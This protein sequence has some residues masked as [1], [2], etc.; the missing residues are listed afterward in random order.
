MQFLCDRIPSSTN[1]NNFDVGGR[2]FCRFVPI[3]FAHDCPNFLKNWTGVS[4]PETQM[5]FQKKRYPW[6][7]TVKLRSMD[8]FQKFLQVKKQQKIMTFYVWKLCSTFPSKYLMKW[9]KMLY[10][11]VQK[12]CK[13]NQKSMAQL[14]FSKMVPE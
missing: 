6:C 8:S 2:G 11:M 12:H 1:E 5:D 4:L 13:K 7:I 10:C 3:Y 9:W 14:H